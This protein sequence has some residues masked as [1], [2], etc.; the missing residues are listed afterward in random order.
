MHRNIVLPESGFTYAGPVR[1]THV[2]IV[3]APIVVP[4]EDVDALVRALCA[5]PRGLQLG[6]GEGPV[7][8]PQY[9]MNYRRLLQLAGKQGVAVPASMARDAAREG[10]KGTPVPDRGGVY[11]FPA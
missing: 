6:S 4:D 2:V 3:E 5:S 9:V 7:V 10:P 1:P 8:R 11:D